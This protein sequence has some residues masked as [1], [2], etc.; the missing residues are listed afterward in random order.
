MSTVNRTPDAL[1]IE[2]A[3]AVA[4]FSATFDRWVRSLVADDAPSY[5]RL[6]LLYSLH[7][8]GPRRMADLAD[9][10]EVTPR[11]ITALVDGLEGEGL[12]RR[13]PHP[14]DRRAT[15]VELTP[16]A[17]TAVESYMD[18]SAAVADL[19]DGLS[20]DDRR[21][22]LRLTR[23]LETRMRGSGQEEAPGTG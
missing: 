5:P 14:T 9:A 4:S 18:H 21:T 15:L 20:A 19:F 10:L 17:V 7:C 12:V 16:N 1:S 2:L 3:A 8:E 13:V 6:R 23:R 11:S 22:L